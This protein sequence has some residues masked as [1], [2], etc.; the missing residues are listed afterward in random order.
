MVLKAN[1][2]M[3]ARILEVAQRMFF[4]GGLAVS[5]LDIATAAGISKTTLYQVFPTKDALLAAV[6]DRILDFW[7]GKFSVTSGAEDFREAIEKGVL[8][9]SGFTRQISP[10]LAF[11]LKKYHPEVFRQFIVKRD[12]AMFQ[13][14]EVAYQKA[15]GSGVLRESVNKEFLFSF[16]LHSLNFLHDQ[17]GGG[18]PNPHTGDTLSHMLDLILNGI[19]VE[20]PGGLSAKGPKVFGKAKRKARK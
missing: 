2:L 9:I 11:G 4:Q 6:L 16:L 7:V 5:T 12:R 14:F 8:E 18:P 20:I 1:E 15:M 10:D 17:E 19:L 13:I 3:G